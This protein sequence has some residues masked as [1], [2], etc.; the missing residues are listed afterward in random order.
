M[1]KKPNV[2]KLANGL[3]LVPIPL[4]EQR[5]ITVLV[6]VETG[7]K[8][9]SKRE[10]G[11]SHFLEHMCFKGTS[12]RPS[13]LHIS[14][15]LDGLGAEYNAFTGHEY[16]GYYAKV[17]ARH[18]EEALDLV[19]DI[20][21]NPLL[22]TDDIEREKGV[23][24]DEINMRADMLP[25]Q[26]GELFMKLLYGDQ[27]AGWPIA[28]PKETIATFKREDFLSYRKLH[29]V[30]RATTV[31]IAGKFD[32][33]RMKRLA[34]KHFANIPT[35]RKGGK[36]ATSE[37]QTRPEIAIK[38]HASDQTHLVLGVR[39][40]GA[41]HPDVVGFNVLGA[42]LGSGMSSRLFQKIREELGTGYYVRAN[43]DTFTD[44]GFLEVATGI[45]HARV[46]EVVRAIIAEFRRMKTEL[47]GKDELKKVQDYL[48]GKLYLGLESSD[49]LA[50]FYGFQHVL[51]R[52]ML[53]P[54]EI[55]AKLRAVTP[56]A[57]QALAK[58]YL[59]TEHLNL[60]MIG[61]AKDDATYRNLLKL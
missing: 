29:Y 50:E 28:G 30:A 11:I 13:A 52:R 58:K 12:M 2:L 15:E 5:T 59:V 18:L 55:G 36:V 51:K 43:H 48:I 23:I 56:K 20:Y 6:L 4:K 47:V 14:R 49:E 8:Y 40:V 26:A 41:R 1:T 22:A 21:C 54:E 38:E 44:H 42:I 57:I 53:A 19:S 32:A 45:D 46:E 10:N 24:A 35:G 27:P 25:L 39:T 33:A 34:M 9:E 16:T 37:K 61:P 7:S 3:T 60:A 31:I 17:E